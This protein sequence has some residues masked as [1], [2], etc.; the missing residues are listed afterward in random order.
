MQTIFQERESS[1]PS[2]TQTAWYQ[3]EEEQIR[4]PKQEKRYYRRPQ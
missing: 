4:H 2:T 1:K 3:K